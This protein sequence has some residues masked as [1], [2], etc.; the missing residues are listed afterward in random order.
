MPEF[1]FCI[2]QAV[3]DGHRGLY[4]PSQVVLLDTK[5]TMDHKVHEEKFSFLFT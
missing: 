5:R 1:D 4:S 3:E 2:F